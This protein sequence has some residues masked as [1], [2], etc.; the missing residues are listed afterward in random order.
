MVEVQ[1]VVTQVLHQLARKPKPK[2]SHPPPPARDGTNN[3]SSSSTRTHSNTKGNKTGTSGLNKDTDTNS[4]HSSS[5]GRN[6]KAG[7]SKAAGI[8]KDGAT[9]VPVRFTVLS[10]S[11][12]FSSIV[13]HQPSS[14]MNVQYCRTC[15]FKCLANLSVRCRRY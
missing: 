9:K 4:G 15:Y 6:N 10:T 11:T 13:D 5:N 2:R 8:S 14:L 3:S 1:L 7:A 12:S